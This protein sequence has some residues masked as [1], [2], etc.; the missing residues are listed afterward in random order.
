MVKRH[1]FTGYI[2][3]EIHR[4]LLVFNYITVRR[5]INLCRLRF[6]YLLSTIREQKI[7]D[8]SPSFVSVET[9]NYCNL[10][11]PECPVGRSQ[12]PKTEHAH[13]DLT[14]YKKLIDE[15]K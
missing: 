3:S 8:L 7:S 10:H 4:L 6:S 11:C 12:T 13:F 15:Q 5:L 9:S 14:L 2:F 1:Q